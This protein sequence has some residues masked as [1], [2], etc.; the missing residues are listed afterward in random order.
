M[1]Y[2]GWYALDI[3]PYREDGIRA[4]TESIRW[5]T[6]LHGLLDKIGRERIDQVIAGGDAMEATAMVREALLGN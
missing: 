5:I 3:F 1:D 6:G 2:T 4:A